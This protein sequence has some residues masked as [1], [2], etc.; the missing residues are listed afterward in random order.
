[1]NKG[2]V[3]DSV[4]AVAVPGLGKLVPHIVEGL[5]GLD[6]AVAWVE[7]GD[8]AALSQAEAAKQSCKCVLYLYK[9]HGLQLWPYMMKTVKILD[10]Q[11]ALMPTRASLDNRRDERDPVDVVVANQGENVGPVLFRYHPGS[12]RLEYDDADL[13][14]FLVALQQGV[15]M[16]E[17][18][19]AA[20]VGVLKG[21]AS[22]GG[23]ALKATAGGLFVLPF[24]PGFGIG[25]L[26]G[27]A[28]LLAVLALFAM[29]IVP[30]VLL[31]AVA[32][33]GYRIWR[34]GQISTARS[35]LI[36][37]AQSLTSE[38]AP[39]LMTR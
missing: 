16:A 18:A 9:L 5:L 10:R 39:S 19:G 15:P 4:E 27:C 34:S 32:Y 25:W 29:Y 37:A 7:C 26:L 22:A 24:A 17:L 6:R 21:F 12:G 28:V 35:V 1:M 8:P 36:E 13:S 3:T 33:G 30:V 11:L 20:S 31:I 14:N 38:L 23:H 2:I